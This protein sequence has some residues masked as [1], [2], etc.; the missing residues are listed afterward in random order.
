M[1]SQPPAQYQ[2]LVLRADEGHQRAQLNLSAQIRAD[3][4]QSVFCLYVRLRTE[5]K[6]TQ[7]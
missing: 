7:L 3:A 2:R 5:K 4:W 6:T 1:R